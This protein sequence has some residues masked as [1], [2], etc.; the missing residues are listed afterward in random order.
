MITTQWMATNAVNSGGCRA[1][2]ANLKVFRF[3]C[4]MPTP[5][6]CRSGYQ[7]QQRSLSYKPLNLN[8]NWS[9]LQIH[10][11]TKAP[12]QAT[13]VFSQLLHLIQQYYR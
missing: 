6:H 11:A 10:K 2:N 3:C 9:L 7:F 1:S 5:R 12:L 13:I 4:A 8:T